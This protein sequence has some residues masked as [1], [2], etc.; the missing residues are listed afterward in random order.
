MEY[1]CYCFEW[2]GEHSFV[3]TTFIYESLLSRTKQKKE[4]KIRR[5]K[6]PKITFH[7]SKFSLIIYLLANFICLATHSPTALYNFLMNLLGIMYKDTTWF[8]TTNCSST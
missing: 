1:Y 8:G 2:G 3:V 4:N 5:K 7:T 6:R